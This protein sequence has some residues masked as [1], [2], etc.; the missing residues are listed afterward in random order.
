MLLIK[1]YQYSIAR[2]TS[3]INWINQSWKTLKEVKMKAVVVF[4]N[5]KLY[6]NWRKHSNQI[7]LLILNST[8]LAII[9]AVVVSVDSFPGYYTRCNFDA[10]PVC[11][12]LRGHWMPFP[13]K[14]EMEYYISLHIPTRGNSKLIYFLYITI[15]LRKIFVHR[16][17]TLLRRRVPRKWDRCHY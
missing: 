9:A 6:R 1:S 7:Y 5:E 15:N 4:G 12:L 3:W 11:V 16:K 8:V 14:C 10:R 13:N 17:E 2:K